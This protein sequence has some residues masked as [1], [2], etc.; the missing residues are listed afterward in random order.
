[1]LIILHIIVAQ[2]SIPSV[3]TDTATGQP[4]TLISYR[5]ITVT[6]FRYQIC[7]CKKT[8]SFAEVFLCTQFIHGIC[9]NGKQLHLLQPNLT[10]YNEMKETTI[11]QESTKV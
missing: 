2:Y 3:V 11:T 9:E 4:N 10:N 8:V 1:M 5:K 6:E 7:H